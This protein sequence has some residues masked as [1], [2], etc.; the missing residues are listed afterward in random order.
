MRKRLISAPAP[1]VL[2]VLNFYLA[3]T[4]LRQLYCVVIRRTIFVSVKEAYCLKFRCPFNIR[5]FEFIYRY[6]SSSLNNICWNRL[7]SNQHLFIFSTTLAMISSLQFYS[8][9]I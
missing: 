1:W 2:W 6:S 7:E 5:L 9:S 3:A 8:G 4:N